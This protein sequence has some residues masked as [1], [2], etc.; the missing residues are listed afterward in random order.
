MERP[1]FSLHFLPIRMHNALLLTASQKQVCGLKGTGAWQSLWL[2]G[3]IIN[4]IMCAGGGS[5]LRP[6]IWHRRDESSRCGFDAKAGRGSAEHTGHVSPTWVETNTTHL[7]WAR[8]D[9]DLIR[10]ISDLLFNSASLI[11]QSIKTT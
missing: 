11:S 1:G 8:D 10:A 6:L 9:S 3:S 2:M 7:P 4:I 5:G